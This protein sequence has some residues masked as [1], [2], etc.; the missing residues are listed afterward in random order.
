MSKGWTIEVA[1]ED[2]A[3]WGDKVVSVQLFDVAIEDPRDAEEAI[4][5]R[6]GDHG[7]RPGVSG[8]LTPAGS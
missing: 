8:A 4:R 5:Q 7:N 2:V 1:T 3:R 6:A